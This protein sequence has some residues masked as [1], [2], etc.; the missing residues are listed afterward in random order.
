MPSAPITSLTAH[1]DSTVLS[2]PREALRRVVD[3]AHPYPEE[4]FAG[5]GIVICAGGAR[6]LTCAWVAINVLRRVVDCR[7]PIELWHLGPGE[8]G[9]L[10]AALFR[11]LEVDVVDGLEIAKQWPARKLGGW[12]LKA[13]AVVQSRFQEVLLLDADNVAVTDPSGLFGTSQFAEIGV[14]FW[15][16]IVR[17]KES[18][19]IWELCGVPF[20]DE[21]S[22][23]TGQVVLDKARCWRP[24]QVALHMNMHSEVFYPHTHGD[25]DTFHLAWI[26]TGAPWAMPP[27]PAR[28]TSTGIYQRDFDGRLAFQHR[29]SAKWRFRGT[30]LHSEE[31]RYETECRQFLDELRS[32]WA[33]WIAELPRGSG[34]DEAAEAALAGTGWFRL[35]EAGQPSRLI[36]LLPENRL[37]VGSD[38]LWGLRWYIRDG[39]LRF[40]GRD[41]ELPV[42]RLDTNGRWSTDPSDGER[43]IELVPVPDAGRDALG[44]AALAVLEALA[45]GSAITEEDAVRALAVLAKVGDLSDALDRARSRWWRSEVVL[46]TIRQVAALQGAREASLVQPIPVGFEP[47]D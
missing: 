46:R 29:S 14:I 17:L 23:E 5:R 31:F 41:D 10:E 1:L 42:L 38:P 7:L 39:Q 8:L 27:Y 36:E 24:L 18:N 16:D 2:D 21:P 4:R 44:L 20:R 30:N 32:R 11:D 45:G 34:A 15:P 22:W 12:E 3:A 13:Y 33:G 35:R 47:V 19:P 37:G 28:A 9:R 43:L 26:L 6:L 40:D 25:K